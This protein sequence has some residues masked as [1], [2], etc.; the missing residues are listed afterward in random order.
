MNCPYCQAPCGDDDLLCPACLRPV[1]PFKSTAPAWGLDAS[2]PELKEP[3]SVQVRVWDQATATDGRTERSPGPP[4]GRLAPTLETDI[5]GPRRRGPTGPMPQAPRP[6]PAQPGAPADQ[7]VIRTEIVELGALGAT[8]TKIVEVNLSPQVKRAV[9]ERQREQQTPP[10]ELTP[11]SLFD[12]LALDFRNFWRRMHR[13]DRLATSA[14]LVG[15]FAVFLP[16]H[17]IRGQGLVA[18]VEGFGAWAALAAVAALGSIY[19]RTA[20][21]RLAVI[22]IFVQLAAAA[23]IGAVPA[24]VLLGTSAPAVPGGLH[25]TALCGG[26]VVALTL[27]R[28][29][30]LS[31]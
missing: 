31:S 13:Y 23:G 5:L 20:R 29:T 10:A 24:I 7:R 19:W 11:S 2:I 18:G 9:R 22:L 14:A 1:E 6:Y 27:A 12:E 26:L 8:E 15:L 16:W 21:R 3:T 17:R 28:S 30:R 25:L 4:E